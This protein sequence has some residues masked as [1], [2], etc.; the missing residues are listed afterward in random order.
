MVMLKEQENIGAKGQ[1]F[2]SSSHN[3]YQVRRYEYSYTNI[4]TFWEKGNVI[5]VDA[6]AGEAWGSGSPA[7]PVSLIFKDT[8]WFPSDLAVILIVSKFGWLSLVRMKDLKDMLLGTIVTVLLIIDA[9]MLGREKQ[10]HD[11]HWCLLV[12]DHF[13]LLSPNIYNVI[14]FGTIR[15]IIIVMNYK[16]NFKIIFKQYTSN[17]AK[18]CM[19]CNA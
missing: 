11:S 14:I 1:V 18:S 8:S 10:H 9:H 7:S 2:M 16:N 13:H 5:Q 15:Y 19:F 12:V 4:P 3:E 6:E 17:P